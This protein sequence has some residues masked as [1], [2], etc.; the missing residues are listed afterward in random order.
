MSIE[1]VYQ[2]NASPLEPSVCSQ[3]ALAT[4]IPSVELVV[5]DAEVL[6]QLL[7]LAQDGRLKKLA[8]VAV[9]L[10]KQDRR[11]TT[12]VQHILELTREFQVEKLEAFIQ[13]FTH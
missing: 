2:S 1:W 3:D 4:S 12:F 7:Q 9:T 13:Q 8:E 6:A 10:E 5:P 11:Y